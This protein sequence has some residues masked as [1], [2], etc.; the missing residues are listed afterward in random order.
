MAAGGEHFVAQ[1]AGVA[2]SAGWDGW[3]CRR[4]YEDDDGHDDDDDEY[5]YILIYYAHYYSLAT[6]PMKGCD[7][8]R[9]RLC[10]VAALV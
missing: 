4:R 3:C 9:P 10:T 8:C 1:H 2:K 6:L 7:S 5:D